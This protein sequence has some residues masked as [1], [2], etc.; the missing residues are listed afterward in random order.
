MGLVVGIPF[1]VATASLI[2]IFRRERHRRE[3][4]LPA[5]PRFGFY[6]L[7]AAA[8]ILFVGFEVAGLIYV[9][10]TGPRR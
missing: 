5:G 6:R 2:W 1:V 10:L 4:G 9:A 7:V 8:I 3:A